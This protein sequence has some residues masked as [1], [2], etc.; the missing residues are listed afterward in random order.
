ML[1][2]LINEFRKLKR[3]DVVIY[4]IV[5]III[6]SFMFLLG[7]FES[8]F[9][10]SDS[11]IADYFSSIFSVYSIFFFS[12]FNIIII[13]K[14][15]DIGSFCNQIINGFSVTKYIYVK[16]LLVSIIALVLLTVEVIRLLFL[17]IL[18]NLNLFNIFDL[19]GYLNFVKL[20]ILLIY[21]GI[22]GILTISLFKKTFRTF[23]LLY[24]YIQSEIIFNHPY[25]TTKIGTNFFRIFPVHITRTFY[26]SSGIISLVYLITILI[27]GTIFLYISNNRLKNQLNHC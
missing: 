13:G 1:R 18:F 19:I 24:F 22:G 11:L 25:F 23:I 14:E 10:L 15:L 21:A 8:N 20:F 9:A 5:Y 3:T 7:C 16:V 4:G 27:Y 26:E 12:V 6:T 2:V 17:S